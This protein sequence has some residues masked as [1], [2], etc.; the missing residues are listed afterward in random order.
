MKINKIFGIIGLTL[1]II[2]I[3]LLVPKNKI[4]NEIYVYDELELLSEYTIKSIDEINIKLNNKTKGAEIKVF[5]N[6]LNGQSGTSEASKIFKKAISDGLD[7]DNGIILFIGK[8]EISKKIYVEIRV[9]SELEKTLPTKRL[10]EIVK[11]KITPFIKDNDFDNA[12]VSGVNEL[13]NIVEKEHGSHY[14][15][16]LIANNSTK[17]IIKFLIIIGATAGLLSVIFLG[18]HFITGNNFYKDTLIEIW[19][20]IIDIFGNLKDN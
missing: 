11:Q 9:G 2:I 19:S 13:S 5:T 14:D 12:I 17:S 16:D 20:T 1:L 15:K 6:N 10:S 8:D 4:T 3:A 7:D 18:L